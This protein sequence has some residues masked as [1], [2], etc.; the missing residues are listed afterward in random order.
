MEPEPLA[1]LAV[2]L[3]PVGPGGVEEGEGPTTLVVMNS[4]GP[5]IERFNVRLGRQVHDGVGAMLLEDAGDLRGV[6][7]VDLLEV[8]ARVVAR[9]GQ[10]GEVAGIRQ[11][12]DVHDLDVGLADQLADD[13]RTDETG[14]PG[15]Q[16]LHRLGLPCTV[17]ERRPCGRAPGISLAG[18]TRDGREWTPSLADITPP[19]RL[20]ALTSPKKDTEGGPRRHPVTLRRRPRPG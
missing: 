17:R 3:A 20:G 16:D 6:A 15:Q 4:P 1:S 13:R 11:L 14:A 12:V 19:S 5:S 7:N 9:L 2:E 10:R 18:G 8:M